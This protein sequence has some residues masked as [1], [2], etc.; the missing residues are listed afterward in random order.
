[1][2]K[3]IL[4]A[5]IGIRR[6]ADIPDPFKREAETKHDLDERKNWKPDR[7]KL[8]VSKTTKQKLNL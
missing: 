5:I 6:P 3:E 4:L 7:N 1:M 8:F 2:L